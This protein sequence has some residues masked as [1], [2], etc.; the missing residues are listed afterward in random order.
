MELINKTALVSVGA[1]I[2]DTVKIGEYTVIGSNQ[3]SDNISIDSDTT[4]YRFCF[5]DR[6]VKIG[7]NCII[8]D[9]SYIYRNCVIGNN[10]QIQAKS[11]IG[12]D[13]VIGNNCVVDANV[14]NK[15]I[16]EDGVRFL[17]QIAHSHRNHNLDWKSTSEES[18]VF[19]KNSIIGV[20]ALIIGPIEVG[21]NSYVA[22]GEILKCDLPADS[23]YIQGKIYPKSFFRGLVS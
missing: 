22:A 5:I 8:G 12:R 10:V 16:M 7:K 15:V 4:I 2:D 3:E 14:S 11:V 6:G 18:P 1:K 21:E 20:G 17:G 13:C 9:G 23:V 19:R